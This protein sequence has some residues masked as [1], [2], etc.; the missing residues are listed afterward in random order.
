MVGTIHLARN[1]KI[2]LS[3][4]PSSS[5][6][7]LLI[8]LYLCDSRIAK[9]G[10]ILDYWEGV[11][12][13]GC[14]RSSL[15]RGLHWARPVC[16]SYSLDCT[17]NAF[18]WSC[19]KV[20]KEGENIFYLFIQSLLTFH[21]WK[22]AKCCQQAADNRDSFEVECSQAVKFLTITF[23]LTSKPYEFCLSCH[24]LHIAFFLLCKGDMVRLPWLQGTAFRPSSLTVCPHNCGINVF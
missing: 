9:W 20:W 22:L 17:Q 3:P 16:F 15:Y 11:G 13:L 14:C 12:S 10:S 8:V 1:N 21:A 18:I 24:L 7:F 5:S 6:S 2:S 4:Q 23:V 19:G